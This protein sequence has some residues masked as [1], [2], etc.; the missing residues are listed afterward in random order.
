MSKSN[1]NKELTKFVKNSLPF[2]I[3]ILAFVLVRDVV[4]KVIAKTVVLPVF[5]YIESS[6]VTDIIVMFFGL[7]IYCWYFPKLFRTYVASNHVY[8][9]YATISVIYLCIYRYGDSFI[10]Y[11]FSIPILS[12]FY[13]LDVLIVPIVFGTIL[14]FKGFIQNR[15]IKKYGDELLLLD[16]PIDELEEDLLSRK[17]IAEVIADSIKSIHTPQSTILGIQGEWGVGKTS[18]LRLVNYYLPEKEYIKV[19]Y[20]PWSNFSKNDLIGDLF[21]SIAT[22]VKPHSQ[23]LPSLLKEHGSSLIDDTSIHLGKTIKSLLKFDENIYTKTNQINDSLKK[24]GKK[25]VISVDDIDRLDPQQISSVIQL[26]KNSASFNHFVFL[27]AYDKAYIVNALESSGFMNSGKYLEKI[28]LMEF[29]VPPIEENEIKKYLETNFV[30]KLKVDYNEVKIALHGS[31]TTFNYTDAAF[32][33]TTIKTLRD[34]KRLFNSIVMSYEKLRGEVY[35]KDFLEIEILRMKYPLVY[36]RFQQDPSKYLEQYTNKR[37]R[38]HAYTLRKSSE[39]SE[40]L[41]IKTVL[42]ANFQDVLVPKNEIDTVVNL[43]QSLFNVHNNSDLRSYNKLSII[44]PNNYNKYFTKRLATHDLSHIEFIKFYNLSGAKFLKQID[45][46]SNQGK[47]AA[48]VLKLTDIDVEDIKTGAE[49]RKNIKALFALGRQLEET[50]NKM[51]GR[52]DGQRLLNKLLLKK[53]VVNRFFASGQTEYKNF[54]FNLFENAPAPYLFEIEFLFLIYEQISYTSFILSVEEINLLRIRYFKNTLDDS[55]K[56]NRS[57]WHVFHYTNLIEREPIGPNSNTVKKVHNPDAVLLLKE[58]INKKD[59]SGFIESAI[60]TDLIPRNGRY[61]YAIS[62]ELVK[63]FENHEGFREYINTI[64]KEEYPAV[65]DLEGLLDA[66]KEDGY[67]NYADYTFI[68]LTDKNK[69]DE[70]E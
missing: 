30:N 40:E 63:L 70:E 18:L 64:S 57:V 48:V 27:V 41:L 52:I 11:E 28:F 9:L 51:H 7:L 6:I 56:L 65:I 36:H 2:V 69:L 24:I 22:A 1:N 62:P 17:E 67:K 8:L 68:V 45:N 10:L 54:V 43:L 20:L 21:D 37:D 29:S 19:D 33:L 58:F 3:F 5:Q 59:I 15:F 55:D 35:F 32:L 4:D 31:G 60:A 44:W 49:Y 50:N 39:K 47:L 14:Q 38:Q 46:W 66:M 13:Y 61:K 34:A 53:S 23:T 42:E 26:I 12:S 25:I 16:E